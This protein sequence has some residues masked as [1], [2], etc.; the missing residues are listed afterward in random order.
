M[1]L[2]VDLGPEQE[3]RL[4]ER[5]A[6]QGLAAAEYARMVIERD[7]Q[8][9]P[10]LAEIL[11]PFRTQ[12]EERGVTDTELDALFE[13]AREEVFQQKQAEGPMKV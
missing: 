6:R 12:V 11:G 7:L 4:K 9:Q 2:V 3:A 10:T 13:E 5:A 8:P 1:S